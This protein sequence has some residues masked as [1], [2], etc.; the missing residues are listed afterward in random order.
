MASINAISARVAFRMDTGE[1][2]NGKKVYSSSVIG[3]IN[4]TAGAVE[5]GEVGA[6]LKELLCWPV[7][8]I[9]ITRNEEL[10]L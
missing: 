10:E 6:S 1:M 4:G 7:S 5:L 8:Q 2:K 3:G 9:L